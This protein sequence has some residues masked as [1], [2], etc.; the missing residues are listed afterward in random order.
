MDGF[1]KFGEFGDFVSISRQMVYG[2]KTA[3]TKCWSQ[4]LADKLLNWSYI[5]TGITSLCQ[6][7]RDRYVQQADLRDVANTN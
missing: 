6:D 5:S 2:K 3:Q 4:R 1:T 7:L